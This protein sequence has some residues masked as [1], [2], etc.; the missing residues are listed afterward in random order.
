MVTTS[1]GWNVSSTQT[2]PPSKPYGPSSKVASSSCWKSEGTASQPQT[3]YAVS[4]SATNVRLRI[5]A[6]LTPLEAHSW[7]SPAWS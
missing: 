5:L 4:V 3:S 2:I 7:S 6:S 1:S